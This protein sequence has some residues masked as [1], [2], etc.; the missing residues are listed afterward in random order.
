M[1]A[2][3]KIIKEHILYRSQIFK[4]AKSDLIKTYRGSFLGWIWALVKPAITIFVYWFAFSVG[5]RSGKDIEGYPFFLWLLAGIIPWFYMNEM[6]HA[7]TGSIKKY[8]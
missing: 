8:N 6:F 7:G 4:L 3:T 1:N 5:L 2:L